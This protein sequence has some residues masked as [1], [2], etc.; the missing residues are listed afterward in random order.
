MMVFLVLIVRHLGIARN[1]T[2][3]LWWYADIPVGSVVSLNENIEIGLWLAFL[4]EV[5][6][7]A[8]HVY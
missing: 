8:L 1:V 3:C 5:S 4:V 7:V 2:L 6:V